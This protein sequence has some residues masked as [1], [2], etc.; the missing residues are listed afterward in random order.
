MA[1]DSISSLRFSWLFWPLSC[2]L[3]E[4]RLISARRNAGAEYSSEPERLC[5]ARAFSAL[6]GISNL[7][8]AFAMPESGSICARRDVPMDCALVFV[9]CPCEAIPAFAA[10]FGSGEVFSAIGLAVA[11]VPIARE[12]LKSGC[13]CEA[14]PLFV[15]CAFCAGWAC[16]V[17]FFAF[18]DAPAVLLS[19]IMWRPRS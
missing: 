2:P 9:R 19:P 15:L 8:I 17:L 11:L 14:G 6:K 16:E 1:M 18:P 12:L 10:L 5:A 7:L 13:A 4:Q 3:F